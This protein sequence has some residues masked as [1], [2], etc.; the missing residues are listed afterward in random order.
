MLLMV[1]LL[2]VL[3]LMLVVL[4]VLVVLVEGGQRRLQE[5]RR[6]QRAGQLWGRRGQHGLQQPHQL[7]AHELDTGLLRAGRQAGR[8]AEMW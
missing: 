5:R 3:L 4:V 7:R 6:Q 2:V 1:V 8:V